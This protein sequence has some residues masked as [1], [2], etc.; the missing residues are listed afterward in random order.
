MY[1]VSMETNKMAGTIYHNYKVLVEEGFST[2]IVCEFGM[3]IMKISNP[4]GGIFKLTLAF[5]E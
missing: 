5:L 3:K 2:D 4:L 1:V